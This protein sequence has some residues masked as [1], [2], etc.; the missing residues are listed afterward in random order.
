MILV[1]LTGGE[2]VVK[3]EI[4][5]LDN[6]MKSASGEKLFNGLAQNVARFLQN[7]KLAGQEI[8]LGF[9][10]SFPMAQQSLSEGTLVKWT[11]GFNCSD[12]IDQNVA[13]LLS[14]ALSKIEVS[15]FTRK[16]I[17]LLY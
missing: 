5:H 4:D 17:Y 15:I 16:D 12:V 9:T 13:D 11:K 3:C 1:K 10:F 6:E 7:E 14:K 2:P 8:P